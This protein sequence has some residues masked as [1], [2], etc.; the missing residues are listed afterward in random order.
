MNSSILSRS[1]SSESPMVTDSHRTLCGMVEPRSQ[2]VRT[3]KAQPQA[4][5]PAWG[6]LPL[7]SILWIQVWTSV[8]PLI[9]SSVL[10]QQPGGQGP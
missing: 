3:P 2:A 10:P 5:I 6:M 7:P 1:R 8:Y 4:L 9:P